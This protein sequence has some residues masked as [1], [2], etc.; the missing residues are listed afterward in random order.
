MGNILT[1]KRHKQ[2]G[3]QI[4]D[5]TY[6]YQR[7]ASGFLLSNRLYHVNDAIDSTIDQ[8]DIDDQGAGFN[9]L[10]VNING[11]YNYVYDEEGRLV[12]DVTEGIHQ[13]VWRVDGKVREINR[14]STSTRSRLKF[15]YDAM[16]R[17]IAKHVYNNQTGLLIKSTYYLLDAQGNTMSTYDYVQGPNQT[18]SFQL[19]ERH[20]FGSARIGMYAESVVLVENPSTENSNILVNQG[21]KQYELTNHLGNVLTVIH[22]IKIPLNNGSGPGVSSY[23]VGIRTCSD[24]SPF[25]VELDGRTVSGGYRYGYQGSEK[26]NETKGNGNS[27]TTEFRQLD[28]RLGRW[29]SVDPLSFKFPWQS[30]YLSFD[31]APISHC[32]PNGLAANGGPGDG[33]KLNKDGSRSKSNPDGTKTYDAPGFSSVNLPANAKVLGTMQ[34]VDGNKDGAIFNNDVQYQASV[35]DLAKFEVDD[36]EFTAQFSKGEFMGYLNSNGDKYRFDKKSTPNN[37]HST[38]SSSEIDGKEVFDGVVTVISGIVTTVEGV[39]L[40]ASEFAAPQGLIMVNTGIPTIGFGFSKIIDG[41]QGGN[42]EIPGGICEATDKGLGGSGTIG[43]FGDLIS[44]GKPKTQF[45]KGLFMYQAFNTNVGHMVT[46]PLLVNS[47]SNIAIPAQK[48]DAL[49]RDNTNVF[50]PH[51]QK[52]P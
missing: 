7:D 19:K 24:Y 12:K 39:G 9:P 23:R 47:N 27:Y 3:T 21:F 5:M 34:D 37:K 42:R 49:I 1:Q 51:F 45:E 26:D 41:F 14:T 20:I 40:I 8:T 48:N 52:L 31:N 36:V 11:A 29:L 15:D 43:Q 17:R 13:I 6:R 50:I 18:M 10:N 4:E 35:G 33:Y 22:D 46:K 28:P 25:G 30:P 38:I 2:N 32:D 44:S 16:G